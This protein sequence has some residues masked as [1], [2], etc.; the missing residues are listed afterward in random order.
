MLTISGTRCSTL[1]METIGGSVT[2][3][4]SDARIGPG[5]RSGGDP[6]I[7]ARI[8]GRHLRSDEKADA[9]PGLGVHS[10]CGP[11]EREL[12]EMRTR[13][14]AKEAAAAG[15]ADTTAS[16]R[17]SGARAEL[18]QAGTAPHGVAA[19]PQ[20][21][22]V[23]AVRMLSLDEGLYALRVAEIGGTADEIAGMAVP[24][25]QVGGPF[26]EDG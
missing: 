24:A 14:Q 22:A 6:A 17:R 23:T 11:A 9:W 10:P 25:A 15:E 20:P 12:P 19:E 4:P 8:G 18:A 3:A 5:V 1:P 2:L 21:V 26:A 16:K 13:A 7:P